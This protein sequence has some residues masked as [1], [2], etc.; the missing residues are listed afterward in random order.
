MDLDGDGN[1]DVVIGTGHPDV[2]APNQYSGAVTAFFGRGDGSLIGPPAYPVG[3]GLAA[4]ALADLD[5]DGKPDL[6]VAAGDLWILL[7][8]GSGSFKT[9]VRIPIPS[10]FSTAAVSSVAAGD[11]NGDGKRDL[12]LGDSNGSGVYVLL[13]NGDGTF[14][15]PVQYPM[16][17]SI[18]SVAVADFNG[19][20][21]L[22][23]AACGPGLNPPSGSTA[24][25]LLGNG[26]GTFQSVRTLSGFG[27]APQSL[28]VGDFNKDGKPDLAIADEG[29]LFNA[30]NPGGVLV[31]LGLGN[32]SFQSPVK[33]SAGNSPTFIA[34]ADINGDG[35]PDLIV[36][37]ED[38]NFS[39]NFVFDIGLLPGNGNGTFRAALLLP[40][41]FGPQWIAVADLNGDGK[42]DLAIAHCCGETDTTFMFGNGD[43]TF[44]P[45][46]EFTASS[47]PSTL[48]VTDL[49][50]DGQ[51]DLIVGLD[52][53][54]TGY[55]SV[56]LNISSAQLVSVNGASFLAGPL[57]PNSFAS[58]FGAGLATASQ[59]AVAPF[60]TNLGG[61]TVT[62][63][64][65]S[66]MQKPAP[67]SYVSPTLVNYIVP[68]GGALG[69][70]TVAVSVSGVAV[71]SGTVVIAAI[72]PGLFLFEP[73]NILAAYVTRVKADLSQ[74]N[75]NIWTVNS[76][77]ALVAAPIDLGP[78]TDQVYLI[79]Y[80]TGVR[81]H[82]AASN[83]VMATA[84]GVSLP[85]SYAGAQNTAYPGLDQVNV[86]LPRSLAGKGDVTIQV[87]VDGQAAE[88]GHVTIQ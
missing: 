25:I 70:A 13:G 63:T 47:S 65:A 51:P 2:L 83:S 74:T 58:G 15:P 80:G 88:P 73:T 40:T 14:Q 59:S 29:S 8:R 86:L 23:I 81:G 43:G 56:F 67:L 41:E 78:A 79:L 4:M 22:D 68:G 38:P 49:N 62:V 33:Y 44:Q 82:S 53:F 9:P 64:D 32:G 77:G 72:G 55:V 6:A 66:G 61:T 5:G 1:L 19:D 50:G 85:V 76:S 27:T 12:V 36:T 57:A 69:P 52:N 24:G 3:S 39:T 71:S 21:K 7:S 54:G 34:A 20:G 87:T 16:G 28:V 30:A 31:Y 17:G 11:F 45:E 75:E 46:L 48:L 10:G 26:N 42:P 18:S 60:P 37:T 84:G 35:A